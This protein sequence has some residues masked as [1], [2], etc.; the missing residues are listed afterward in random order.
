M[1]VSEL[2]SR[3]ADQLEQLLPPG[4]IN[5]PRVGPNIR[6]VLE[7]LG[8]E[9]ARAHGR[10][11]QLLLEQGPRTTTELLADWER[12]V[13]LPDG[14]A[15]ASASVNVRRAAV[16]ARL[17]SGGGQTRDALEALGLVLGFPIT[18]EEHK[19]F[20]IGSRIGDRLYGVE[21]GW[22]WTITVHAPVATAQFFQAGSSSAGDPLSSFETST[23]ECNLSRARQAHSHVLFA[24]DQP[25]HPAS[26]QPWG[27][28]VVPEP[29]VVRALFPP[30]TVEL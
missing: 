15:G 17:V 30:Y 13:G 21:G 19:V 23:L 5:K 10:V 8:E 11:D 24:Y 28:Y 4:R 9:F 2:A 29:L 12:V 14:C 20:R 6:A 3:Y 18:I 7:A 22:P 16:L 25:V 1:A 27:W 26:Y